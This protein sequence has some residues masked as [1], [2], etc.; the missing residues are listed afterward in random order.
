MTVD[1]SQVP[2]IKIPEEHFDIKESVN[3]QKESI[4]EKG[5]GSYLSNKFKKAKDSTLA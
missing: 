3:K 1:E 5:F 4:K 2:K